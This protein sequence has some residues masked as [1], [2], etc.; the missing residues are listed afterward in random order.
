MKTRKLIF[1]G[2]T[3]GLALI[4]WTIINHSIK[5][6]SPLA[7][8]MTVI[9]LGIYGLIITA[10][11]RLEKIKGLRKNLS[12]LLIIGAIGIGVPGFGYLIN[13]KLINKSYVANEIEKS[14]AKWNKLG[15]TNYDIEKQVELTDTFTNPVMWSFELIRFNTIVFLITLFLI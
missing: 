14:Y 5:V 3:L 1:Y 13:A 11:L 15:Y 2:L 10:Y 12:H 7:I 4:I 8:V 6:N 9:F